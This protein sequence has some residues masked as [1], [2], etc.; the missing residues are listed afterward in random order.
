MK[1]KECDNEERRERKDGQKEER[2]LRKWVEKKK[3]NKKK[4]RRP[5][6]RWVGGACS[7]LVHTSKWA[8]W[9]LR[10]PPGPGVLV[11]SGSAHLR[12]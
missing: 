10:S 6:R 12:G 11:T 4:R 2:K 7:H 8:G 5:D 3:F 9:L 1:R